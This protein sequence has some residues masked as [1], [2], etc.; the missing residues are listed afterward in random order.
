MM[1]LQQRPLFSII[2]TTHLRAAL[3]DRALRSLRRQTCPDYEIIIVSDVADADTMAVAS[4]H[5]TDKDTFVKR[6]GRPGPAE[7][8]NLGV[9]MARGEWVIFLDDDDSFGPGHL[10]R[11]KEELGDGRR[12]VLYSDC[13]VIMEDRTTPVPTPLSQREVDIATQDVSAVWV[14]N[15]IPLHCLV[16]RRSA[17][18]GS[19]FDANLGSLE[20]WDFL[21]S[22]CSRETPSYFSGGEAMIH[23]DYLDREGHRGHV[24]SNSSVLLDYIYIYHKW[25]APGEELKEKRRDFLRNVGVDFGN[26]FF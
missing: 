4:Q 7:S 14:K 20:D 16:Y 8:R 15:F 3:L 10:E 18:Q 5:L 19:A 13:Q 17:M 12:S 2:I 21:L 6:S 1:A 9:S 24:G 22:I 25:Q 26:H 11:I 23:Q